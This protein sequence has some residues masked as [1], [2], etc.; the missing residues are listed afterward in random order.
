MVNTMKRRDTRT[1][2]KRRQNEKAQ[3][4][5]P[6]KCPEDPETKIKHLEAK[7]E[8]LKKLLET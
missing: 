5:R 1:R 6:R 2:G 7:L 3:K 4:G 8:M